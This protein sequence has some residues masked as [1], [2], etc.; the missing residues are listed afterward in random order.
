MSNTIG[1]YRRRP[2]VIAAERIETAGEICTQ[3]GTFA[4]KPGDM[5]CYS[6][7]KFWVVEAEEFERLYEAVCEEVEDV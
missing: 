7:F 1:I 3:A 6:R 4:Y 5:L 2:A